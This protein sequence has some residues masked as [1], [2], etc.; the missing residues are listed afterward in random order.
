[1]HISCCPSL[2][3]PNYSPRCNCR[4]GPSASS[5]LANGGRKNPTGRTDRF[6][7]SSHDMSAAAAD[8]VLFAVGF[9]GEMD[10]RQITL[11]LAMRRRRR[12]RRRGT[13]REER[14]DSIDRVT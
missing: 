8:D 3:R 4:V 9:E 1:M 6:M 7:R 12:R 2:Q 5:S 10:R 13:L 11:H 14:N